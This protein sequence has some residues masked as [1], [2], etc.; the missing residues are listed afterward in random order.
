MKAAHKCAAHFV[1]STF[2]GLDIS[3]WLAGCFRGRLLRRRIN[4]LHSHE[5]AS[6]FLCHMYIHM[7]EETLMAQR[8]I[9]SAFKLGRECYLNNSF[10]GPVPSRAAERDGCCGDER[11]RERP[12]MDSRVCGHTKSTI[13]FVIS[14]CLLPAGSR[15]TFLLM[16][17]DCNISLSLST[18]MHWTKCHLLGYQIQLH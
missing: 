8:Q 13:N 14:I 9:T 5:C 2:C 4:S 18:Q 10:R 11:E 15:W 17:G 12:S 7:K 3:G 1:H 16:A 6:V